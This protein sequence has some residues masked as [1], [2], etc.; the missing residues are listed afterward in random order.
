VYC[1]LV[2]RR[3]LGRSQQRPYFVHCVLVA[4]TGVVAVRGRK[5][6]ICTAF[7]GRLLGAQAR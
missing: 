3:G 7:S 6:A 5:A 4:E 1:R 2:R